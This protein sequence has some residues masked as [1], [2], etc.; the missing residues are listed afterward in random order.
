V[1]SVVAGGIISLTTYWNLVPEQLNPVLLNR[2]GTT[3]PLL[4]IIW[5]VLIK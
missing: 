4:K 2:S 5:H 3:D 1:D